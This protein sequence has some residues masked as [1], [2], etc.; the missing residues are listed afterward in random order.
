MLPQ[1]HR[2]FSTQGNAFLYRSVEMPQ[3]SK[4]RSDIY[5]LDMRMEHYIEQNSTYKAWQQIR[6]KLR[7]WTA[8]G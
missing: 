1:L 8:A 7:G 2:K 3:R 6:W 4:E 5:F